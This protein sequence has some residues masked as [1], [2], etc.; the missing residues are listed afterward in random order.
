MPKTYEYIIIGT[1]PGGSVAAYNLHKAGA[2]VVLIEAGKFF[3]K[4]TFPR[5]EADVAAQLYWGGGIEFDKN[6]RMAFLRARVVGG[7]SIVNQALLDRFDDIAFADWKAQSGVE[8]FNNKDMESAYDKVSNFLKIYEFKRSEFNTNAKLFTDACDK[9]GYKWSLLHRGQSDCGLEKGNDCI[10]CLG[11]CHRDSKQS[12]MATYIQ[13][14]EKEGLKVIDETEISH[15]E[16]HE[17]G[18]TV[19]GATRGTKVKFKAKNI[20]LAGGSFGTT[21]MLFQS[22]YKTKLPNLGKNFATHP[23]F[24]NFGIF[25][26]EVNSHK[27]YFQT[28]AS[29]DPNFR[30]AGFK[31]E[32]VFAGPVSLAMLFKQF[33]NDLHHIMKDYRKLTCVEIAV[34]DENT[35]EIMVNN[36]G[37]LVLQKEMT[38]QD[39]KRRDAGMEVVFNIMN[40]AGAKQ[41]FQAPMYFGLHLMGG[42]GM[43]VDGRNS[44]VGP[45]FILHGS[46]RV[47]VCDSS[48]FPNAPGINPSLTIFALSQYLS[49]QLIK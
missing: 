7:T 24:M 32:C 21:K 3:R 27:G 29:K 8:F 22:G 5:N 37:R 34:R 12:S 20:I 35:G 15:F 2:D 18:V 9:L 28:V 49:E 6:A 19:Y 39:K 42:A 46:K 40:T 36:K 47:Y 4:D 31:L 13:T 25:D 48:L 45:D 14:G 16:E 33:G 23:Q 17:D 30:K 26:E 1:G 10:A 43:G 41:V 38:D 44:V 11:G